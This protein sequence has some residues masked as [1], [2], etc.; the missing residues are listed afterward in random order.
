MCMSVFYF[1]TQSTAIK[2]KVYVAIYRAYRTLNTYI[3]VSCLFTRKTFMVRWRTGV[4]TCRKPRGWI[5]KMKEERKSVIKHFWSFPLKS[6][7]LA[8]AGVARL[9]PPTYNKSF[10]CGKCTVKN[11]CKT[12]DFIY[13]LSYYPYDINRLLIIIYTAAVPPSSLS[14]RF[15]NTARHGGDAIQNIF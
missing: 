6:D 15:I 9:P 2:R 3:L 1:L 4:W 5:K 7:I 12:V 11:H 8:R 10:Y 14:V 13:F